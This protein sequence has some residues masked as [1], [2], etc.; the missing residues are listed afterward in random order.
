MIIRHVR[1]TDLAVIF[2]IET[3]NFSPAEVAGYEA[4]KSRIAIIPDTFLVAEI[5]GQVAGYIEGPAMTERH[6]TDDLFKTVVKNPVSGGYITVTSLSV[7]EKFQDQSVGKRLIQALKELAAQQE[8]AG[9]SLTCH[10]Y[11]IGYYEKHGFK[12][13]GQ[14]QSTYGGGIWYDMVWEIQK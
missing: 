1:S 11:L 2:Q 3:A 13:D 5:D 12:N 9:I 7:A 10:D 8:R 4:M 6:L 14:S